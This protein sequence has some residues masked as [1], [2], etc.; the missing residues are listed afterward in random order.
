MGYSD[1]VYTIKQR[2]MGYKACLLDVE[3]RPTPKVL[4]LS[5]HKE[6]SYP[7]IKRFIEEEHLNG[8]VCATSTICYE[9]IDVL[10]DLP[11]EIQEE[12]KIISYD[13]NRWLDYLKYPVSVISQPT[14]E[15][16]SAALENLVQLIEQADA[17]YDVKRELF[18]EISIID[19]LKR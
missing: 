9:V 8:I 3:S 10:T 6:D 1:S 12:M 18:F 13:D 5:Y 2:I 14:A 4:S 17:G 19:R 16:G 11:L 15:I 7:L